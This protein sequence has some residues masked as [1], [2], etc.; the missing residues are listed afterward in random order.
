LY[1]RNSSAGGFGTFRLLFSLKFKSEKVRNYSEGTQGVK[2]CLHPGKE[3]SF[4]SKIL[5]RDR[6]PEAQ[7]SCMERLSAKG[8]GCGP[9]GLRQGFPFGLVL[10]RGSVC[11]I[12]QKRVSEVVQVDTHLMGSSGL[13]PCLNPRRKRVFSLDLEG[14]QESES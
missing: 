7:N 4:E 14:F 6:M 1:S 5:A 8:L 2:E 11:R 10:A 13:E 12:T 9:D 3:G